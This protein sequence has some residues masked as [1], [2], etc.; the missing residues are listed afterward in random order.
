LKTNDGRILMLL[1]DRFPEDTRVKNE[2][3]TLTEAGYKVTVIALRGVGESSREVVNGVRV[4]R[5]PQ[6][7]MFK[8]DPNANA[9]YIARILHSV[10]LVI[11]YLYE[12][13]YFT[14][15]C[16]FFSLFIAIKDG[17]DVIH[18]HNPPDT[19]FIVGAFYKLFGKKFVFDH[20]DLSPELYLSRFG[21]NAGFIYQGLL[22]VERLCLKSANMVISTNGSY[23]RIAQNRAG[24]KPESVFV[25]RNGPDLQRMHLVPP[26]K[27]LKSL[28]KTILCYIG[29]M[30]PQDG[31]DYLLRAIR[32]LV[33]DFGRKNVYCVIIGSGDAVPYLQKLAIE[34]KIQDCVWFTGYIPD[35]D[36][37]RYLSTVD[38][39]VDPD[40][41][42][43][44][45]D[46]ST[47]I[48]IME[49]MALGKPIV[50]FDLL[51]TR[52]SAQEAAI[53]VTPNDEKEFAKAI[54]RLMDNAEE[55][56]KMGEFG[57]KRIRNELAWHHVSKNLLLAYDWLFQS[58][59]K[60]LA[61]DII[62]SKMN[63]LREQVNTSPN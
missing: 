10:K 19:L 30:N 3:N 62:P 54:I 34:L 40:P 7:E 50:S 57:H 8:K 24:K 23:K 61:R 52:Y 13:L 63:Y 45:N 26:D 15:A 39:C 9:N 16:W 43:P 11:G 29:E 33:W 32:H 6:V 27:N 46:V 41:K 18:A 42:S 31:V 1:E 49:Y 37:I 38:I 28:N 35:E 22:K 47:W 59:G 60:N 4:Y 48:K 25:V 36:M 53:Y 14:S 44:L 2:A 58:N 12:Y 5:V 56:K 21:L 55:R 51:E 17:F 20:H